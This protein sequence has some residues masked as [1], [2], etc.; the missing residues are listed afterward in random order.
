MDPKLAKQIEQQEKKLNDEKKKLA[1]LQEKAR[2]AE[3]KRFQRLA[4][5]VGLFDAA[6]SDKDMESA[7]QQLVDAAG[8]PQKTESVSS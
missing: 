6:V 1:S 3:T 2:E 5:K 7:L 4:A 8:S